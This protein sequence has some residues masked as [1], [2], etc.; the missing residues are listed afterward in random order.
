MWKK[1]KAI[2]LPRSSH[3]TRDSYLLINAYL[4][5]QIYQEG[6]ISQGKIH[7]QNVICPAVIMILALKNQLFDNTGKVWR[8]IFQQSEVWNSE[9]IIFV[10]QLHVF[11]SDELKNA[12]Y[13]NTNEFYLYFKS[14][15][16]KYFS[17]F[18]AESDET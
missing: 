18:L 5:N 2:V 7:I 10:Q 1:P 8:P 3:P 11:Y 16:K 12:Y 15:K 14:G 4:S 9:K 6:K 17:W 13:T